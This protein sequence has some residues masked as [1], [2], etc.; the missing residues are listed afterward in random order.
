[1]KLHDKLQDGVGHS[2]DN[3]QETLIRQRERGREPE[4]KQELD[5]LWLVHYLIHI[6]NDYIS[7]CVKNWEQDN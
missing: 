3:E 2:L 6:F 4:R 5:W 7:L 1:M